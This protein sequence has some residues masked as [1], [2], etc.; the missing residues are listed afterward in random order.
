MFT[1]Y[2]F[3]MT[4]QGWCFALLWTKFS[5]FY[6]KG[7]WYWMY[8]L[9]WCVHCFPMV[10]KFLY[11]TAVQAKHYL[12]YQFLQL[13]PYKAQM[14]NAHQLETS[15]SLRSLLKMAQTRELIR[16]ASVILQTVIV[17]LEFWL[18]SILKR[19][20]DCLF[21]MWYSIQ[22]HENLNNLNL[23]KGISDV[24]L[25]PLFKNIGSTLP[26]PGLS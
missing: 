11:I 10:G 17:F 4:G 2:G 15:S 9:L 26:P 22:V 23:S 7:K 21:Y 18:L 25:T 6:I 3:S 13:C 16:I 24:D 12:D 20:F 1:G 5:Y 19:I 8:V 14:N